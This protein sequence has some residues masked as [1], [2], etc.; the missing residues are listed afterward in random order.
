MLPDLQP[1]RRIQSSSPPL[2]LKTGCCIL[3]EGS[4]NEQGMGGS[5]FIVPHNEIVTHFG[6]I[7][8]RTLVFFPMDGFLDECHYRLQ[9]R[10][11]LLSRSSIQ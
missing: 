3:R 4:V 11:G 8:T 2:E 1:G 10:T 6:G 9:Q 7:D 5:S